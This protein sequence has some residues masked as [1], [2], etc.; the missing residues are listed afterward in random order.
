V[1]APTHKAALLAWRRW[2][3]AVEMLSRCQVGAENLRILRD[4]Y[5]GAAAAP[6]DEAMA[7]LKPKAEAVEHA[8]RAAMLK[9]LGAVEV[10]GT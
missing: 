8:A 7:A 1:I 10:P 3:S 5:P 2:R 4:G 6:L 9:A